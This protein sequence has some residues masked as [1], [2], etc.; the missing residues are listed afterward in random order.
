MKQKEEEALLKGTPNALLAVEIF[1]KFTWVELL[2]DKSVEQVMSRLND[3]LHK[4]PG[5]L[6]K[7]IYS[8]MEPALISDIAQQYF[9]DKH[10]THLLTLNHAPYAE[11]QIRTIKDMIYKRMEHDLSRGIKLYW[12]QYLKDVLQTFNHE[13]VSS[14]TK[15]T[16][17]L[18]ADPKNHDKVLQNLQL[19]RKTKH[20][21]APLQ[22]GDEVRIYKK[23][24]TFDKE[25]VPIWS[26]KTYK[27][28][29]ILEYEMKFPQAQPADAVDGAEPAGAEPAAFTKQK[30]Y[31]VSGQKYPVQ[32]SQILKV[33]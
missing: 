1:S 23:K 3:A 14:V 8:D 7:Y 15:M 18:A 10:I 11:R 26:D 33:N 31:K 5:G 13:M 20:L 27:I 25:R 21:D 6:P 9:R 24:K 12:H 19:T 17:I 4:M 29:A 2:K 30:F 28:E 32:R 22:V 16:P